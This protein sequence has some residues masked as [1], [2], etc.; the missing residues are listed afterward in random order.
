LKW[1]GQLKIEERTGTLEF[2]YSLYEKDPL[3]KDHVKHLIKYF[4]RCRENRNVILHS[5]AQPINENTVAFYSKAKTDWAKS[6]YRDIDL[7]RVRGV[8]DEIETGIKYAVAIFWYLAHRDIQ[9]L[10]EK[11]LVEPRTGDFSGT[12]PEKPPLPDILPETLP[13][14]DHRGD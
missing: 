5:N 1:F 14:G 6:I 4:S 9:K 2:I 3:I 7:S 11:G 8:A 13:P 12:L 10:V